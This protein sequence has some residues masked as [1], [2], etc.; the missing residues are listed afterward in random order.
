MCTGVDCIIRIYENRFRLS[1]ASALEGADITER[2]SSW[3]LLDS[4][5]CRDAAFRLSIIR[6]YALRSISIFMWP[7]CVQ[8]SISNPGPAV[9]RSRSTASCGSGWRC[10]RDRPGPYSVWMWRS[11]SSATQT[12]GTWTRFERS[13]GHGGL[14]LV[15]V[16]ATRGIPSCV[17]ARPLTS[18]LRTSMPRNTRAYPTRGPAHTRQ[19]HEDSSGKQR[20]IEKHFAVVS[21][22]HTLRVCS[23]VLEGIDVERILSL[24]SVAAP[25]A[26]AYQGG[27]R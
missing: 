9:L 25:K 13:F 6:T 16:R 3:L 2:S 11:P 24:P 22:P 8:S 26:M 14:A 5:L 23:M 10:S 1:C 20:I 21:I 7:A 18:T 12:V 27:L 4:T 19:S 15:H 17:N